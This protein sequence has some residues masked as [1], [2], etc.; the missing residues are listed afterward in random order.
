MQED[1]I[2]RL[3]IHNYS[4]RDNIVSWLQDRD[5]WPLILGSADIEVVLGDAQASSTEAEI[6][7][8]FPDSETVILKGAS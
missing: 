7:G 4:E 8:A 1:S 2:V 5:R 3:R 6:L